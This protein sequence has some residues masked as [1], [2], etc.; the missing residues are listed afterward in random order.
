MDSYTNV[1]F[2]DYFAIMS[3]IQTKNGAVIKHTIKI[4]PKDHLLP[5][6]DITNMT[7]R[8]TLTHD[9]VSPSP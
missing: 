7:R 5:S 6:S 2:E 9:P 8:Q 3:S 4:E 1:S